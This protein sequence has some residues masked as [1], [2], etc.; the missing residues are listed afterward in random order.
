MTTTKSPLD[1]ALSFSAG[2]IDRDRAMTKEEIRLVAERVTRWAKEVSG[3]PLDP[4]AVASKLEDN[5]NVWIPD[6]TSLE[7]NTDHVPWLPDKMTQINWHFWD[8]YREY[9]LTEKGWP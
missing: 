7:D 4:A 8:R 2:L 3:E 6:L 9:L 5:L 1:L